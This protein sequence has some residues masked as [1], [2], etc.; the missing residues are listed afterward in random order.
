MA[1]VGQLSAAV[2]EELRI[3]AM[4][5]KSRDQCREW[6]DE[7][8]EHSQWLGAEPPIKPRMPINP[9]AEQTNPG[10]A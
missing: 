3:G 2:S 10:G 6:S 4:D 1:R 5:Q 7:V 8:T 9:I